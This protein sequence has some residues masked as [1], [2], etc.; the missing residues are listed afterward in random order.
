[1][2]R[3]QYLPLIVIIAEICM[4]SACHL[5][6][7]S[8]FALSRWC[9]IDNYNTFQYPSSVNKWLQEV[10]MTFKLLVLCYHYYV[11]WCFT[12]IY[13]WTHVRYLR[14]KKYSYCSLRLI[15]CGMIMIPNCSI[16]CMLN[17]ITLFCIVYMLLKAIMVTSITCSCD[18]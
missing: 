11:G 13:A 14:A 17:F 3:Q 1:M 15:V 10:L 2:W 7:T 9:Y 4:S 5:C 16:T 6:S 18:N 8:L 12:T